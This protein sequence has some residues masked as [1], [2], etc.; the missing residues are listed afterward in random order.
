VCA[1]G[2]Y[3]ST[4][5]ALPE[6]DGLNTTHGSNRR[7]VFAVMT[8]AR[9]TGILVRPRVGGRGIAAAEG[10]PRQFEL[11]TQAIEQSLT[12]LAA[13]TPA[14]A[15]R[16]GSRRRNDRSHRR[17]HR[18]RRPRELRQSAVAARNASA[19]RR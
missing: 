9:Q 1:R 19:T 11:I 12:P 3:P 17:R 5:D 6:N 16:Y 13:E 15:E 14:A 7:S 4:A 8:G 10:W 18:R 2:W